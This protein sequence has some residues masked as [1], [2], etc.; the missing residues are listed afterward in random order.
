MWRGRANASDGSI[1]PSNKFRSTQST[2]GEPIT[3][4][5]DFNVYSI[6]Y[7]WSYHWGSGLVYLKSGVF[8]EQRGLYIP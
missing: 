5:V 7:R 4:V 6:D 8:D 2:V 3:G 1:I